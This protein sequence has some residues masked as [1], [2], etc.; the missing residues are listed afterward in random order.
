MTSKVNVDMM[1]EDHFRLIKPGLDL[2]RMGMSLVY[3]PVPS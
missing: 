1:G 2:S 3:Y